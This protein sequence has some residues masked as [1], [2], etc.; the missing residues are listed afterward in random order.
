MKTQIT[1]P[2]EVEGGEMEGGDQAER[3]LGLERERERETLSGEE[4]SK[5]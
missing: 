5:H 4:L 2:G 1:S 3:F